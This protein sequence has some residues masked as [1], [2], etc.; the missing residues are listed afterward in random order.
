[1]EK[2][3]RF[4][5][6]GRAEGREIQAEGFMK[7]NGRFIAGGRGGGDFRGGFRSRVMKR[8]G[9]GSSKRRST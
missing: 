6:R 8:R 1:M 9:K 3:Y 7:G 2:V 4:R 5:S